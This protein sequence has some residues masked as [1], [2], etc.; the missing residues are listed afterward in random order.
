MCYGI[1]EMVIPASVTYIGNNVFRNCQQLKSVVV[2]AKLT[3][4]P[5]GFINECPSLQSLTLPET[6]T[7]LGYLAISDNRSLS[8]IY[9]GG[10]AEQWQAI[11][12]EYPQFQSLPDSGCTVYCADGNIKIK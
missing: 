2:N 1:T 6:I 10:T 3:L 5:P 7:H 9:F 12:I 4:L 8:R 11:E